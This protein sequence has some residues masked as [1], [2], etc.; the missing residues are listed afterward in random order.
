MSKA[1]SMYLNLSDQTQFRLNK[2]NKIKG[3]FIARNRKRETM[4][5]RISK[6]IAAFDYFGKALII[7]FA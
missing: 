5:K 1:P 4:S 6:Y 3:H 2:I 7:L